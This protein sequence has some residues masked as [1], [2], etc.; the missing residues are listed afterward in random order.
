MANNLPI[1]LSSFYSMQL[2]QYRNNGSAI[3]TMICGLGKTALLV[4]AAVDTFSFG[5][6][7]IG[8]TLFYPQSY[9]PFTYY[10]QKFSSAHFTVYRNIADLFLNFSSANLATTEANARRDF[11]RSTFCTVVKVMIAALNAYLIGNAISLLLATSALDKLFMQFIVSSCYFLYMIASPFSQD[12]EEIDVLNEINQQEIGPPRTLRRSNEWLSTL[13]EE[14][15]ASPTMAV[16]D[17]N[18]LCYFA[19]ELN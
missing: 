7:T 5:F 9:R 13:F 4:T 16:D 14:I 1:C 12:G 6:L 15:P 11:D 17:P 10:S 18:F 19:E 8:A 2:N 3:E